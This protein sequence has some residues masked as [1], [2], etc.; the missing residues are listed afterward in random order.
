[1]IRYCRDGW[2]EGVVTRYVTAET[3]EDGETWERFDDGTPVNFYIYY[4]EDG[5]TSPHDLS[6]EDYDPYVGAG[7][8]SWFLLKDD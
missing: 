2:V 8:N 5:D 1:M 4:E 3:L 7:P 6:L